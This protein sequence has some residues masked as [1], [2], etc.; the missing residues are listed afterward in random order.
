MNRC[1]LPFL[2]ALALAPSAVLAQGN[3][4]ADAL[5]ERPQTSGE[6]R[7]VQVGAGTTAQ[8]T[9]GNSGPKKK[10]GEQ[11]GGLPPLP[12]AELCKDHEGRPSHAD[13]LDKVLKD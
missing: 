4:G 11:P 2:A 13:C 6:T 3:Q 8:V 7:E 9:L 10:K 12:S 1:I 5:A